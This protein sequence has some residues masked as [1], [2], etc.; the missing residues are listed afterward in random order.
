M[1]VRIV[2]IEGSVELAPLLNLAD[3]IVDIVET[4]TTLKENGLEVYED[5]AAVSARLI[6]NTVSLKMYQKEIEHIIEL[7][8]SVCKN[9][10]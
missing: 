3:G 5:A 7:I 9:E 1:D 2:K 4:G 6:V 8:E 10:E